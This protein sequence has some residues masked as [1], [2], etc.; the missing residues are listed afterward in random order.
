MNRIKKDDEVIVITGKSKG[1][2][3]KVTKTLGDRVI[4]EG[5]NMVTKH[6]KPNPASGETGGRIQQ[7]AS[8]H[9]SNV[10]LAENGKA[11]KVGFR[12]EDGKK[13]RFSK[14]SN[15]KI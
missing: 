4:V 8:I 2:V 12:L 10:M 7:E 6:V 9:I 3:G 1:L 15:S 5:A 14:K 11:V 13:I